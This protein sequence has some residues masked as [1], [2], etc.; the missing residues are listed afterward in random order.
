MKRSVIVLVALF[1]SLWAAAQ[2]S[3]IPE[4]NQNIIKY[5]DSV[6]GKQVDRGECWDLANQALTQSGAKFDRSSKKTLYQFGKEVDPQTDVIYPGDIIQFENVKL[7]YEKD[8]YVYTESMG[9]HTAIV[10]EVYEKGN[11]RLA[12]Q[13]TSFSGRKVGLSDLRLDDVKKGKMTFYR[14]VKN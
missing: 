1:G 3:R 12:H 11:Y 9:H 8:N 10:Y 4:L 2:S 5:I 14:P 6:V 13:N 7:E